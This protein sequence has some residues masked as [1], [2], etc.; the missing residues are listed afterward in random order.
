MRLLAAFYDE[1]ESTRRGSVSKKRKRGAEARSPSAAAA[2]VR[3]GWIPPP[4]QKRSSKRAFKLPKALFVKDGAPRP[5]AARSVDAKSRWRRRTSV[6]AK[7]LLSRTRRPL[8]EQRQTSAKAEGSD[9][10][11]KVKCAAKAAKKAMAAG[12]KV[13]AKQRRK[14]EKA[15]SKIVKQHKTSRQQAREVAD[16]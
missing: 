9:A 7:S 2:T 11:K 12:V 1:S 8:G 16:K 14:L 3:Q 10:A 4:E 15:V 5:A 6:S 13:A